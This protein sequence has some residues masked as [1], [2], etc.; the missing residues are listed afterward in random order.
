MRMPVLKRDW[1]ADDLEDLP[2]DG[3]RYEIIDGELLVPDPASRQNPLGVFSPSA[4]VDPLQ[5][6]W[7]GDWSGRPWNEVV[8]Y[9]LHV[10][11]FTR[12][13]HW[14]CEG[15]LL[16]DARKKPHHAPPLEEDP[17]VS[18]RVDA[19]AAPGGPLHGLW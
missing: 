8:L 14:G 3:N 5:F 18:K 19:L 17:A 4:V 9:E 11:A 12:Q 6:E 10:G 1:T 15:T 2:D 16:I 13:K 7:D